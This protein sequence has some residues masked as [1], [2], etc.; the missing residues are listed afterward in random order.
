MAGLEP[1]RGGNGEARLC[2]GQFQS[3]PYTLFIRR[4]NYA[5]SL[6]GPHAVGN[7]GVAVCSSPVVAFLDS[8]G[9]TIGELDGGFLAARG[10]WA[11]SPRMRL[12]AR[13]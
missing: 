10:T 2:G 12:A 1:A 3:S 6:R 13:L 7:L 8:V 4:T 5:R 9:D 11:R